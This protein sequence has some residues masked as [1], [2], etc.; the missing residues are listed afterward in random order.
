MGCRVVGA[1]VAWFIG[2]LVTVLDIILAPIGSLAWLI[3]DLIISLVIFIGWL[4][5]LAY[6]SDIM[7]HRLSRNT[8][9]YYALMLGGFMASITSLINIILGLD[10]V[11]TVLGKQAV[12]LMLG[13]ALLY[14]VCMPWI[15][16]LMN[17]V[18][19]LLAQGR[20]GEK[21]GVSR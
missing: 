16:I 2:I 4:G 14:L 17:P 18:M 11:I 12:M 21:T 8:I 13:A 7:S 3:G 6:F 20:K 1:V 5:G 10:G 9:I 15:P 19:K